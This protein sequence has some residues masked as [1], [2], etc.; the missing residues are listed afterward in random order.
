MY[1]CKY[2]I[3][4]ATLHLVG[5]PRLVELPCL[6]ELTCL[7]ELPCLVEMSCL[8]EMSHLVECHISWK[9]LFSWETYAF[10]TPNIACCHAWKSEVII[11]QYCSYSQE[12]S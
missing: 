3:S 12:A 9:S 4:N 8:M 10:N 6:M 11:K 5:M 7:E 1:L 2:K